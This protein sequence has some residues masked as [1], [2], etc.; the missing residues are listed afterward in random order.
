MNQQSEGGIDTL[1]MITKGKIEMTYQLLETIEFS[2]ARK[3]MSV[4]VKND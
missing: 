4:I 1:M 3:R 2:S